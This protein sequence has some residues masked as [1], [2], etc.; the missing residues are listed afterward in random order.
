MSKKARNLNVVLSRN[1]RTVASHCLLAMVATPGGGC[2]CLLVVVVPAS[3][4]TP[5]T[6]GCNSYY[7]DCCDYCDWEV[8]CHMAVVEAIVA[9]VAVAARA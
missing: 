4:A 3:T 9:I 2:N 6:T 1:L 8:D 5:S 7:C